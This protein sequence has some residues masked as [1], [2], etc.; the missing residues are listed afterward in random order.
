MKYPALALALAITGCGYD[1]PR[2]LSDAS[3]PTTDAAPADAATPGPG[4]RS[5]T[6]LKLKWWD[7]SGTRIYRG[8]FDTGLGADCDPTRWASGMTYCTPPWGQVVYADAGCTSRLGVDTL[9]ACFPTPSA[10]YAELDLT[11]CL[12]SPPSHLFPRGQ[13]T[14]LTQHYEK[15]ADGTCAGPITMGGATYSTVGA[16][17]PPASLA[18]LTSVLAPGSDRVRPSYW[19]SA[20]GAGLSGDNVD[21]TLGTV[22]GMIPDGGGATC[23]PSDSTS[24]GDYSDPGCAKPEIVGSN[25]CPLPAYAVN[26]PRGACSHDPSQPTVYPKAASDNPPG[27]LY[28]L[29]NGICAAETIPTTGL[30]FARTGP[31]LTLPDLALVA[32]TVAGQALELMFYVDGNTRI[33]VE[34]YLWSTGSQSRCEPGVLDD[35]TIHCMPSR[36]AVVVSV[37]ADAACTDTAV[38]VAEVDDDAP[39]CPATLTPTPAFAA[40]FTAAACTT[41]IEPYKIGAQRT[42]PLYLGSPGA[43]QP[44]SNARFF[45][46]G[47]AVTPTS[48]PVGIAV[49]DP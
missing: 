44:A 34:H 3:P 20:D 41:K 36:P 24:F 22:C 1:R 30:S 37:H 19:I 47:P 32:D 25:T 26:Y 11:P 40:R 48:F 21:T 46:L 10:Y 23:V 45:T 35:G 31:A 49:R 27:T 8:A 9:S 5:G 18:A 7:F 16:E 29:N 13:A 14:A 6:R 39:P 42:G 15:S 17:I 12:G 33:R 43:C 38:D 2:A 4:L 28:A